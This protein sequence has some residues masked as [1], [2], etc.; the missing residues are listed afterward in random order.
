M[1]ATARRSPAL[2]QALPPW[3]VERWFNSEPLALS[4]LRGRVVVV[5]AFQMLC[6]GCVAHGLPQAQRIADAFSPRELVVVGLHTVFEHHLAM[7]PHA[8][9]AFLHEYRVTFP[10][11]VDRHDG[12]PVPCTMRSYRLAGT[13]SLLCAD[14]EGRLAYHAF[15]RPADLEVGAVLGQLVATPLSTSR[16]AAP[17]PGD[18]GCAPT[19][20]PIP[21]TG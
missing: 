2:G 4:A 7:Q 12:Q 1:S 15:G 14:R 9:E 16:V 19:G 21:V 8:L 3:D 11:A 5:A 6:P 17:L 20:C 10:V 18:A 13:P